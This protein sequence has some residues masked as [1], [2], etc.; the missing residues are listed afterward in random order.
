MVANGKVYVGTVIDGTY[1]VTVLGLLTASGTGQLRV[2]VILVDSL[3]DQED[4]YGAIAV[5]KATKPKD[6]ENDK[7]F[8]VVG[9]WHHGQEIDDGSS[10]GPL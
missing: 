8:L 9:P 5:Y 6:T 10:L 3:W 7:V 2:P 4:I 1:G